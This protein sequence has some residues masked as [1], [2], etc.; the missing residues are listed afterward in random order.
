MWNESSGRDALSLISEADAFLRRVEEYRYS[1]SKTIV[2]ICGDIVYETTEKYIESHWNKVKEHYNIKPDLRF[3]RRCCE[4]SAANP[5]NPRDV[6]LGTWKISPDK[7]YHRPLLGRVSETMTYGNFKPTQWIAFFCAIG[8]KDTIEIRSIAGIILKSNGMPYKIKKGDNSVIDDISLFYNISNLVETLL[9]I[10]N[11]RASLNLREL[12][13]V[14]SEDN[15][16]TT[17]FS[18]HDELVL[19]YAIAPK[20]TCKMIRGFL[21]LVIRT[22]GSL[23]TKQRTFIHKTTNSSAHD[24]SASMKYLK[25]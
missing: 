7:P 25:K 10:A 17:L 9:N 22:S 14:T 8:L 23:A 13:F 24:R 12:E 6:F 1:G 4:W 18:V 15:Q 19:T 3:F 11:L 5:V 20:H 2:D 16:C 21:T